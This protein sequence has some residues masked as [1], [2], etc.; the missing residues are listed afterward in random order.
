[1]LEWLALVGG[2]VVESPNL[3]ELRGL[4]DAA[5]TG[6]S[7]P[8]DETA[9]PVMHGAKVLRSPPHFPNFGFARATVAQGSAS[10]VLNEINDRDRIQRLGDGLGEVRDLR[11]AGLGRP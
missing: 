4:A 2:R 8:V 9:K 3:Y 5:L 1:M 11:R 10:A 7:D 6:P